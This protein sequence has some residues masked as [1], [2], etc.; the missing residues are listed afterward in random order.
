M[1]EANTWTSDG[2]DLWC[3][4]L[5]PGHTVSSLENKYM[6][7]YINNGRAPQVSSFENQYKYRYFNNGPAPQDLLAVY[8][9]GLVQDWSNQGWGTRTQYLQYSSTEFLVLILYYYW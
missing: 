8:I 3:H 7:R 9:V 6:Y 5:S 2:Q 1:D 4:M